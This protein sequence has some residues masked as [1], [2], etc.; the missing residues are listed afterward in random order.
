[1]AKTIGTTRNDSNKLDREVVA[2]LKYLSNFSR[3]LDLPLINCEVESNLWWVKNCVTSE[4]L[5]TLQVVADSNANT[6]ILTTKETLINRATFQIDNTDLYVVIV[7]LCINDNIK[8]LESIK[9]GFK[10]K[11]SWNKHRSE[12][13]QQENL[14]DYSN[15]KNYYKSIC[16]G[17]LLRQTNTTISR[18]INFKGKLEE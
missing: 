18:K 4:K 1:M 10:R 17:N 3:Y 11:I 6:P 9:Q 13:K 14:L 16:I 2:P 12:P 15:H 5:N 8:F 7:T